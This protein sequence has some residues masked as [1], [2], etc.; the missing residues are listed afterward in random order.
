MNTLYKTIIVDDEPPARIGLENLLKKCPDVFQVIDMA[1]NATEAI[2]KINRLKP[3]LIF[4]DIE[5]PGKNGFELLSLLDELPI[6]VFCTAYNQYSLEAF[7]TNSIDYIVKP[8][9]LNRL[10]KTIE[11]LRSFNKGLSANHILDVVKELYRKENP[12]EVTS[13]TVRK[14]NKLVL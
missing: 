12:K 13:I 8:V 10:K 7:E 5:M 1:Q 14:K 2:E 4:L 11:K 3:D 6:I 9:E